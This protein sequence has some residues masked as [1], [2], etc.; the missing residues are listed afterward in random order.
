VGAKRERGRGK[1]CIKDK[2]DI[3]S[4]ILVA[5]ATGYGSTGEV[6]KAIGQVISEEGAEVDVRSVKEIKELSSYDAIILGSAIRVGKPLGK[7]VKF[8][9]K[10]K[11][12]LNQVPFACFAVCLTM[13][14]DTEDNRQMVMSYLKP[15]TEKV[16]PVDA[17]LF[18]GMVETG[19]LSFIHRM[20]IKAVKAP[21]GDFRDFNLIRSW[22]KEVIPKLEGDR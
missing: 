14:E 22:A 9:E 21:E 16:K 13:K 15:I 11:E 1:V 12:Y 20:M 5:Y 18:G 8:V 19:K 2:E 3:M 10:H 4:K 6:A 17:G 7:A